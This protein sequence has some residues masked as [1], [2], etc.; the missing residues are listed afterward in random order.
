MNQVPL[1]LRARKKLKRIARRPFRRF[2]NPFEERQAPSLIVHCCYHKVGTVW[3]GRILADVAAEFG[4]APQG[5]AQW[6]DIQQLNLSDDLGFLLDYSS[7]LELD[8]LPSYRASHMIRDPRDIVVSG[9]LY[10]LWTDEAWA[11]TPT[12]EFSR[13]SYKEHLQSLDQAEGL[14]AEIRRVRYLLPHMLDWDYNNPRVFEIKYEH[15][16]DNEEATFREMFTHYGFKKSVVDRCCLIAERYSFENMKKRGARKA[17]GGSHLR[18]GQSGEWRDF[19][20]DE[21]KEL[22]KE[23]YP[24]CVVAL[25]YEENDDW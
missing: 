24:K 7:C 13:K 25:G 17:R 10:H 4:L 16:L 21:H 11:N 14:L 19:F 18:S 3:F 5:G 22:F 23:L 15:I 12:D 2:I 8:G 6:R 9:Y 20:E 1:Q